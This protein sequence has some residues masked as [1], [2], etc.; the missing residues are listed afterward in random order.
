MTQGLCL[1]ACILPS[2]CAPGVEDTLANALFF[3]QAGDCKRRCVGDATCGQGLICRDGSCAAAECTTLADCPESQYCTGEANGRCLPYTVC[4]SSEGCEANFECRTFTP[5]ACP[6]GFPCEQSICHELPRCLIDSDCEV[7]SPGAATYCEAGHCQQS[8]AC[9][10]PDSCPG[11]QDC[12]AGTCVPGGCRGRT[13][14]PL[15]Q[16][17]TE[18]TCRTAPPPHDIRTLI[19]SPRAATLVVGDSVKLDL[20]AFRFD[21][22]SY[23]LESA[24]WE[25]LDSLGQP[26]SAVSVSANGT[27]LAVSSETVRIRGSVE[28]ATAPAVEATVQVLPTLASG[29]RVVVLDAATSQP[30]AGIEV[31]G[32]DAPPLS[33]PCPAP[34]TATTDGLG[35]ALFGTFSGA[36]ANFSAGSTELRSDGLPRY[37]IVSIAATTSADVA[38][39]LVENPVEAAAGFTASLA[40]TETHSSGNYWVGFAALS[41]GDPLSADLRRLMGETFMA[42]WPG[43]NQRFAIPGSVVAYQSPAFG[44]S[45]EIKGRAYGISGSGRK[46][47]VAFGGKSEAAQ[48][49]NVR[50]TELLAYAGAFDYA[51]EPPFVVSTRPL[52]P[53]ATDLDG[54]GLCADPQACPAGTERLP[55]YAA[56]PARGFT[57]NR[58]QKRRTEVILPN[59][60]PSLDTV[61]LTAV[62]A[63]PE[64]GLIP[65]GFSSRAAGAP[66]QDGTRPVAPVVL[67]SG[68]PYAGAEAGEPGVFALAVQSATQASGA[69]TPVSGR[70]T[71][72]PRLPPSVALAP[73]LPL[74]SGS[75]YES[76]SRTLVTAQPQWNSL[77]AA[78][79]SL[80]RLTLTGASTVHVIWFPLSASQTAVSVPE[81]VAGLAAQDPAAEALSA[82]EIVVVALASGVSAESGFDTPGER[83]DRLS[84]YLA[85]YSRFIPE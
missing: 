76:A 56:F 50:S 51:I 78:G 35:I 25:V 83:L 2:D 28:G 30:L 45:Q 57:P 47:G 85:A 37:G 63:T 55:D 16:S 22:S 46:F 27:V 34:V 13:D 15:G 59:V 21:G 84:T 68:A 62:E 23:P 33:G 8:L 52:V 4:A 82:Q 77:A 41:L 36:T 3:C 64:G 17:C 67:R 70:L 39:P 54:D 79:A 48:L 81:V 31:V 5:E 71:R 14:C 29:K 18:G 9:F 42:T 1:P 75:S 61:V 7:S 66:L 32:C 65:L 26:S 11:E 12:I 58:E 38:I 60:P 10:G 80:G 72:G 53:D 19:L 69:R 73:F 49:V 74:A 44:L 43:T 40:F 20:I 6:P 24:T